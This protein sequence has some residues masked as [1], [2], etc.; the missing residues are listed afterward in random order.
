MYQQYRDFMNEYLRLGHMREV[1]ITNKNDSGYYF[2]HHA[3]LR[4]DSQTTKLRTVFN[5]SF[6]SSTGISLND[7]L[8]IGPIIQ[9]DLVTILMRFRLRQ[10]VFS[11]DVTKMYRQIRVHDDDV[12]L[13]RIFWRDSISKPISVYE[14]TT[15]TYGTAPASYLATKCLNVLA[16]ECAELF[17]LA[18]EAIHDFA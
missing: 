5:A 15:V 1:A 2:P 13:Q 8:M 17:P 4:P 18:S 3:V 7:I 14:L 10:F 12:H 11:A 6:R 16:D 9:D